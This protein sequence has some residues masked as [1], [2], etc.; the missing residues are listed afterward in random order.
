MVKNLH[1]NAGNI[2]D[3]DSNPWLGRFTGERNANPLQYFCQEN[4]TDREAWWATV[5][6]HKVRHNG[7]DLACTHNRARILLEQFIALNTLKI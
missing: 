7:S 1:A 6:S 2:R 5:Q 4:P 3:V